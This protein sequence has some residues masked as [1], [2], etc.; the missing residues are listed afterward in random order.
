MIQRV[1]LIVGWAALVLITFATLSPIRGRPTLGGLQVEHFAAF[2][3]MGFA[4]A[5][6][7]PR[8]ALSVLAMMILSA[9]VLEGAQ[10]LTP[11]R[12]GRLIDALVK[13]IGGV[14]GVSAGRLALSWRHLIGLCASTSAKR[15]Q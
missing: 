1:A 7:L 13:V 4:F 12:H 6:G 3:V 9:L 11:D 5:F 2:A 15:P 8:R 10:L 14:C